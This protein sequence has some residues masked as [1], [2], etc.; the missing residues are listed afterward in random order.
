ML[1][2]TNLLNAIVAWVLI[3][4][5]VF[6]PTDSTVRRLRSVGVQLYGRDPCEGTGLHCASPPAY[7]SNDVDVAVLPRRGHS[8]DD[9][10]AFS[11][12]PNVRRVASNRTI[13]EREYDVL[14]ASVPATVWF[15]F[16]VRMHDGTIHRLGSHR[17]RH[18]DLSDDTNGDGVVDE[19]DDVDLRIADLV[20]PRIKICK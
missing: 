4:P 7:T 11:R 19:Q 3:A 2:N 18:R 1:V 16:N 17:S 8:L 14:N 15:S 9:L 13:T 20:P 6:D 10:R 12:L 5:P